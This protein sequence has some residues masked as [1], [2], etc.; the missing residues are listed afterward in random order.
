[1]QNKKQSNR[2]KGIVILSVFLGLTI[3]LIAIAA[4]TIQPTGQ[5]VFILNKQMQSV[6]LNSY[7]VTSDNGQK[8]V[9]Y[10]LTENGKPLFENGQPVISQYTATEFNADGTSTTFEG[11]RYLGSDQQKGKIAD[12]RI[13]DQVNDAAQKAKGLW[14][15]FK[16][17]PS[18]SPVATDGCALV[19]PA[20]STNYGNMYGE[21]GVAKE[22]GGTD[23][24]GE[25]ATKVQSNTNKRLM[26]ADLGYLRKEDFDIAKKAP[27]LQ[28]AVKKHQKS[29]VEWAEWKGETPLP[30]EKQA[31]EHLDSNGGG[32]HTKGGSKMTPAAKKNGVGGYIKGKTYATADGGYA[33]VTDDCSF[34]P[35]T[36]E[37]WDN[38]QKQNSQQVPP[39]SSSQN[40]QLTQ[41][42]V[43]SYSPTSNML[44]GFL[45]APTQLF[46]SITS[47]I[48]KVFGV[49]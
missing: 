17:S 20:Q 7:N 39:N 23:A 19:T 41:P 27:Q 43:Q 13:Q 2:I 16:G 24:Y 3:S 31:L 11:D 18:P 14:D 46:N 45:E 12:K 22:K 28:E 6:V 40:A 21:K 29:T 8:T 32:Y 1:M 42:V 15:Q 10:Q 4:N 44:S 30:D 26:E 36:K 35:A 34:V 25:K 47:M 49:S 48:G 33:K 5:K 37:D 9:M 38:W